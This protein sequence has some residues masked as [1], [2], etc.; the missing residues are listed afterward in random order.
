MSAESYSYCSSLALSFCVQCTFIFIVVDSQDF[1]CFF[2]LSL[3]DHV[4]IIG[5][6]SAFQNLESHPSSFRHSVSPSYPTPVPTPPCHSHTRSFPDKRLA[7]P[8]RHAERHHH[9]HTTLPQLR[10]SVRLLSAASALVCESSRLSSEHT[11]TL[12]VVFFSFPLV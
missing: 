10:L 2:F 3:H 6:T 5:G 7:P 4:A 1:F 11:S 8:T 12:V 9:H